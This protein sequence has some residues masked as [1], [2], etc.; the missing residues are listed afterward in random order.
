[1]IGT[2]RP[3]LT[4]AVRQFKD[5]GLIDYTRGRI[6]ITNRVGLLERS[7]GCIH[8]MH[9]EEERLRR[10]SVTSSHPA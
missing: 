1:M 5:A 8:I 2:Q 6:T 4:L 10:E 9:D 3:S 7:C